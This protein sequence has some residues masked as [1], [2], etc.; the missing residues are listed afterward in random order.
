MLFL[1]MV[2]DLL[3]FGLSWLRKF[4]IKYYL[5]FQTFVDQIWVILNLC[6]LLICTLAESRYTALK[7]TFLGKF[8]DGLMILLPW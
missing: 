4:G 2:A 6:K 3:T 8:T 5:L 1:C 7:M